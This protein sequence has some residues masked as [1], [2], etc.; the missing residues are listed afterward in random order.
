MRDCIKTAQ[1]GE[2]RPDAQGAT[3]FEFVFSPDA[4]VFAGHFPGHPILPGV[5]QLE[6]TRMAAESVLN[7]SLAINEIRKAKF[8]R[9]IGP[10]EPVRLQLRLSPKEAAFEARAALSVNG[11]AAGEVFLL[12][13]AV[14]PGA[15]SAACTP[16]HSGISSGSGIEAA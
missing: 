10:T 14:E 8:Q 9:P 6:M 13:L 11:Q 2:P 5:F 3:I 16:L 1:R 15:R 7:S 12:L 4:A